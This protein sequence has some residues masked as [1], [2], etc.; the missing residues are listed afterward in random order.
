MVW[1]PDDS[2]ITLDYS[3][4]CCQGMEC[5]P[6]YPA[7]LD[8]LV[9]DSTCTPFIGEYFRLDSSAYASTDWY[10][11]NQAELVGEFRLRDLRVG[12]V[13]VYPV[14]YLASEDSLRAWSDIEVMLSWDEGNA[15]WSEA[16][17]GHFD[18]LIGDDLLG[19]T[20]EPQ[21]INDGT[22]SV[23]RVYAN[24]LVAG[25]GYAPDYVILVAAGLDG[26]AVTD[27]AN[28]RDDL[29]GFDVAIV[30]TDDVLECYGG[31]QTILTAD[32]IREFTED[33][34]EWGSGP[35]DR[36]TYLLLIGDHEDP[37]YAGEAWFLP[38]KI[39]AF[40]GGTDSWYV[41]FGEPLEDLDPVPD[42]LVGRLPAR[43]AT[44]LGDMVDLIEEFEAPVSSWPPPQSLAWRRYLTRLSGS[45]DNGQPPSPPDTEDPYIPTEEWVEKLTSWLGYSYDSYYVGDGETPDEPDGSHMTS[46][47]WV[48]NCRDVFSRGSQVIVYQ[49]H[50]GVHL[51][52]GGMNWEAGGPL[53]K[54]IPD[55]TFDDL[56][57]EA[58]PFNIQHGWPFVLSLC[59]VT[60][61][62][63]HTA[64]EHEDGG[65]YPC[66]C[67]Y[68]HPRLGYD[69][70][71]DCF[72]E[73][74]MLNTEG[75]AIGVFAASNSAFR[76]DTPYATGIQEAIYKQG[77]TRTGDAI[78][79]GRIREWDAFF[80]IDYGYR[81]RSYNLL[82]D[83]AV[84][85]GDRVKFPSRCN[86]VVVPDELSINRYPTMPPGQSTG[87]SELV[88]VIHNRG[89]SASGSFRTDMEITCGQYSTTLYSQCA[90]IPAGGST[91]VRFDW[92]VPV[93]ITFPAVIDLH[94]TADPLGACSDSWTADNDASSGIEILDCYPSED[95]WPIL[96]SGSVKSPPALG[97]L[98]GDGDMEIVVVTGCFVEAV[99]PD[100]PGSPLWTAGPEVFNPSA[101]PYEGCTIPLIAD[102][103]G[104]ALP[105]VIV[106]SVWELFVYDGQTGTVICSFEHDMYC[107]E[108]I[109][110]P[111]SPIAG[112]LWPDG[113]NEIGLFH[114]ESD[115]D[116]YL[117]ILRVDGSEM[118]VLGSWDLGSTNTKFFQG[119]LCAGE[120]TQDGTQEIVVSYSRGVGTPRYMGIWSWDYD[121][122][123]SQA[124][125]ID[126]YEWSETANRAGIPAL[127]DLAGQG[128]TVVLSHDD[129]Y[130]DPHNP[131]FPAFLM[132]P[133]DLQSSM[134]ECQPTSTPSSNILCCM[135]ADWDPLTAG[136]DRIIAPAEN[137]C[138]VWQPTGYGAWNSVYSTPDTYRPPFGA[139]GDLD[140]NGYSDLLVGTRS[141]TVMAF[142]RAGDPLEDLG[143][144]YTLPSEVCGGYCIA[145]IDLDG[146]VE[147]VFG[148]MDNYLHVWELGECDKGYAPWPQVQHDAARTGVLE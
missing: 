89:G 55:S 23:V 17:L 148:T 7:P 106:D 117:T 101:G 64:E 98:D 12:I 45:N 44:D 83:P 140:D 34:W 95:G 11:E 105:E 76:G 63:T 126:S 131:I 67:Y 135:M 116:C 123:T 102:V 6:V 85:L 32:M 119:W 27:L 57:V 1:L 122:S 48:E 53:N 31:T 109:A 125:F 104:T 9:T 99:D 60:G 30:R 80:T 5:L 56:D 146:R 71:T 18:N 69:F 16:G 81:S 54:G 10:P 51:F 132:D 4:S 121:E 93:S 68:H 110:N 91:T 107:S 84:D 26:Q 144:P 145:D 94:A 14:Q 40:G 115:S 65:T 75:G 49:D 127:G 36:P 90:S 42:M 20:P 111:S 29:N 8:S 72:A 24:R 143:F 25:P 77:C 82:G 2:D 50:G 103:T 97:D 124:G 70:G 118:D 137:Q 141:G 113:G 38:L 78:W 136:L 62:F 129:S 88:C 74:L 142:D 134:V 3:A 120:L 86:L 92:E 39:D 35:G 13:D 139:L 138:F 147:V 59:C 21:P 28:H 87:Q 52:S 46:A 19:Y 114:R 96:M 79:A 22:G 15:V 66:C 43:T 108:E 128:M 58:L 61:R 37:G 112:D 133:L 47:E 100:D 73:D 33:M 130:A 41:G